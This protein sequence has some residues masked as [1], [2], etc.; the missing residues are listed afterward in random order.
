[1]LDGEPKRSDAMNEGKGGCGKTFYLDPTLTLPLALAV[2][3][4][5]PYPLLK[6]MYREHGLHR[7]C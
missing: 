3:Y 7:A 4:H 1:M 6:L 2:S 5:L